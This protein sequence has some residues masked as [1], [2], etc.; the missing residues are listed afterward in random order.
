MMKENL[1]L[2]KSR[3]SALKKFCAS[4]NLKLNSYELLHQALTHSSYANE[5]KDGDC[6]HNE[7]LEFLGDSILNLIIS[8][9]L[10][11]AYPDLSEGNLSYIRSQVVC[12]P[13]L[14]KRAIK[15]NF[16]EDLLLGRGEK[17][18]GGCARVS[19]LADAFEAVI[20]A[21]FLDA[22][23]ESAA[24][25]V[26]ENLKDD[27]ITTQ[28]GN[29]YV[30]VNKDYKSLLQESLQKNG[31]VKILYKL[32]DEQ[33]PDHDKLFK[34]AVVVDKEHLGIGTGKSKKEAEQKAAQQALIKL[35]VLE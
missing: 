19:I 25:Y 20:G 3:L 22:G 8:R 1:S 11:L 13:T 18:S 29:Y 4:L 26:I 17:T 23:F 15:L 16:G 27:I 21:V 12:E 35:G 9:H 28:S 5:A 32:L 2:D 14:A 6:K 24:N 30:G 34:T 31:A 10:F 7:R 33:G